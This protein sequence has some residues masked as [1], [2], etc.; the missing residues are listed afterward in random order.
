MSETDKV[1][2]PDL[3]P[4]EIATLQV[5]ACLRL[6]GS[7]T[8]LLNRLGRQIGKKMLEVGQIKQSLG[9]A[10][11]ELASLKE[12]KKTLIGLQRSLKCI[13]ERA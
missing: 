11:N 12:D 2:I 4:E 5:D 9:K 10:E 6:I 8:V 7:N 13:A 1:E 3:T